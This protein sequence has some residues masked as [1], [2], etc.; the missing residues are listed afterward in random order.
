MGEIVTFQADALPWLGSPADWPGKVRPGEP[1]VRYKMLTEPK[2]PVPGVQLIEFEPDHLEPPH[3]HPESEVFWVLRGEFAVAGVTLRPGC[4]AF[5]E[6][7][8]VYPVQAGPEGA[9]F[10]RVGLGIGEA[11][12]APKRVATSR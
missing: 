8:T 9:V 5:I 2:G 4:G 11:A 6:K 7:D 1:D 3:S 12:R 10:L